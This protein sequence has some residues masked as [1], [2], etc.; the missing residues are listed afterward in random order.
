MK[1]LILGASTNPYRYSYRALNDLLDYG[2]EVIALGKTSG[3]VR[4]IEIETEQNHF[5]DVDTVTVYLSLRNQESIGDYVLGLNP[6]RV[7]FNPGAENDALKGQL[8]KEE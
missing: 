1:V 6:R 3:S 2:H 7:I 4:N 8:E 5:K